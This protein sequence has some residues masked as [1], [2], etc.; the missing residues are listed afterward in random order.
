M[1]QAPFPISG[2]VYDTDGSTGLDEVTVEAFNLRTGQ[3]ISTTTNALGEYTVDL[4]EMSSEYANEDKILLIASISIST[5]VKKRRTAV[6]EVDTT[7]GSIEKNLTLSIIVD[8][9][10]VPVTDVIRTEFE[11]R[12][13]DESGN[14]IRV[15]PSDFDEAEIVSIT[16][17]TSGY[18]T[19]IQEH[20]GFR[21]KVTTF[22]RDSSNRVS[23]TAVRFT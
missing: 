19:Q 18:I 8:R 7:V 17:N 22:T 20:D 9:A 16:Y 2:K 15:K 4:T 5:W 23:S 3:R 14:A 10:F 13:F 12:V 11:N 21:T 6:V 1:P